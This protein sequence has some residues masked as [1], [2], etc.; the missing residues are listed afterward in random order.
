[1][2]LSTSIS[3]DCLDSSDV[4]CATEEQLSYAFTV[5]ISFKVWVRKFIKRTAIKSKK[6]RCFISMKHPEIFKRNLKKHPT[7]RL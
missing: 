7:S 3:T 5:L 4:H 6:S 1:M 2:S